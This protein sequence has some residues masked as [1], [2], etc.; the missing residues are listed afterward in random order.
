MYDYLIDNNVNS[1]NIIKDN[2][3][4]STYDSVVRAK[5]IVKDKKTI[6]ITQKYHLYRSVFIAKELD[7]DT[8]GISAK[9]VNYFGQITREIREILA[10]VKDYFL[11]KFKIE[12]KYD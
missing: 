4:I 9:E 5:D 8:V 11:T 2:Y 12:P 7:I 3:G 6:I 10:R 1:N